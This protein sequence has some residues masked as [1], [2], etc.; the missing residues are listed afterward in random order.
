MA[1]VS[2]KLSERGQRAHTFGQEYPK[3]AVSVPGAKPVSG[4]KTMVPLVTRKAPG[5][6]EEP[7]MRPYGQQAPT[8]PCPSHLCSAFKEEAAKTARLP[9]PC[10]WLT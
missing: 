4:E 6:Q 1:P 10:C 2:S 8:S 7:T 9:R 3:L 5:V